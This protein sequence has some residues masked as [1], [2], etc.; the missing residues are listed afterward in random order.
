MNTSVTRTGRSMSTRSTEAPR[1]A[2]RRGRR[3]FAARARASALVS[4]IVLTFGAAPAEAGQR[5]E[6]G[7]N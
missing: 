7:N 2:R 1:P 5:A 3:P 4:A 6:K